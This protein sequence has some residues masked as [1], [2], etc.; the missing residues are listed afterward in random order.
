MPHFKRE[1]TLDILG[2]E[3][4]IEIVCVLPLYFDHI[5]RQQDARIEDKATINV[6]VI[7][8]CGILGW[9]VVITV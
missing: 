4:E 1:D 8:V 5:L 9:I 7:R 3:G 2:S 6:L